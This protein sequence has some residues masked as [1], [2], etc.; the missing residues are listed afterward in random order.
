[1]R[2]SVREDKD[3]KTKIEPLTRGMSLNG[4][5]LTAKQI[6]IRWVVNVAEIQNKI[7][8][9]DV[10]GSEGHATRAGGSS[11]ALAKRTVEAGRG[12]CI[13]PK[14]SNTHLNGGPA[15]RSKQRFPRLS[16][17]R[18]PTRQKLS[19]DAYDWQGTEG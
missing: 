15:Q 3:L 6:W 10:G 16:L 4:T 7:P 14:I 12:L 8:P 11:K 9:E 18:A 17:L 13:Q 19:S 1:M 2:E 5:S